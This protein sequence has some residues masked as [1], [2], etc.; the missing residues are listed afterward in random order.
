MQYYKADD[1]PSL[2]DLI[3][4]IQSDVEIIRLLR[5]VPHEVIWRKVSLT[6]SQFGD[7]EENVSRLETLAFRGTPDFIISLFIII[8]ADNQ[9]QMLLFCSK[10]HRKG[11]TAKLADKKW[12]PFCKETMFKR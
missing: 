9:L 6:K 2:E 12:A 5:V 3:S 4:I 10:L 8:N 11:G 1:D 7:F